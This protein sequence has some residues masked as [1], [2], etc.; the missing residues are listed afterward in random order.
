MMLYFLYVTV[1]RRALTFLIVIRCQV[2]RMMGFCTPRL[3]LTNAIAARVDAMI[4]D[5]FKLRSSFLPQ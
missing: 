4:L 3:L 2:M 1:T 5:T